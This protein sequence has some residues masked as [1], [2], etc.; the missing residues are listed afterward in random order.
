MDVDICNKS[1]CHW[2]NDCGA[3]INGPTAEAVWA[4]HIGK[5]FKTTGW[6]YHSKMEQILPSHSSAQGTAAYH[7]ALSSLPENEQLMASTSSASCDTDVNMSDGNLVH[8]NTPDILSADTRMAQPD[9]TWGT[10]PPVPEAGSSTAIV[11][12]M[13]MLPPPSSGS[14]ASKHLHLEMNHGT[15]AATS[16]PPSTVWTLVSQTKP[17]SDKKPRLATTSGKTCPSAS[18]SKKNTKDVANTA[19]LMNL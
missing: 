2:D 17:E 14:S 4:D 10:P 13:S 9:I 1:G 11:P 18:R 5:K 16:A 15:S 6:P 3:N 19:V 7:P 8:I 12:P